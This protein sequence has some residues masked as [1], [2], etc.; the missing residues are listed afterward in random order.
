MHEFRAFIISH[1]SPVTTTHLAPVLPLHPVEEDES[2]DEAEDECADDDEHGDDG[3]L[4]AADVAGVSHVVLGEAVLGAPQARVVGQH[5]GAVRVL[6]A[7][8]ACSGTMAE[9]R[10][11][12]T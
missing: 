4:G 8:M 11:G 1:P 6:G 12:K 7:Q 5:R 2:G 3:G 10:F 9:V